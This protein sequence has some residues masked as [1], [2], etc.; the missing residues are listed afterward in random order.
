[1]TKTVSATRGARP[2]DGV[3]IV[4]TLSL[5]FWSDPLILHFYPDEAV[6]ARRIGTFCT[7]LWRSTASFGTAEISEYVESVALWRPPARW[8]VPRRVI[9][10]NLGSMLLA[11]RGATGRVVDCLGRME[12]HHPRVPHWYLMTIGTDPAAQGRGLGGALISN[13]L[14]VC[15]TDRVP[16]YLEAA[17]SSH[18]SFY[19]GFGFEVRGEVTVREGPSFYPMWR[20]PALAP[21]LIRRIQIF[22]DASLTRAR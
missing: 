11:Y 20:E 5:D 3:A 9:I 16:A 17:T 14:R 8:R 10:G 12:A 15:D 7:L 6:C 19:A 13:R 2:A 4:R 22:A 18:I 21:R 1:M